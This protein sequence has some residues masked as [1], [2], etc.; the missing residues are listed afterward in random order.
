MNNQTTLKNKKFIQQEVNRISKYTS[1]KEK[2]DEGA[3][4]VVHKMY[5]IQQISVGD[6][7]N[8]GP[9]I[10][11]EF[12]FERIVKDLESMK[13]VE[14]LI[15]C[16]KKTSRCMNCIKKVIGYEENENIQAS[17]E[18]YLFDKFQ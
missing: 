13:Q 9:I 11:K 14:H 4:E 7:Q 5:V 15:E 10:E 8:I 17:L 16:D 3:K 6:L 18:D 2:K 1:T 12:K